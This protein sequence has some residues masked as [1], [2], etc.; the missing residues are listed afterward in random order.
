M[1]S[2][3]SGL[4]GSNSSDTGSLDRPFRVAHDT[5]SSL[6]V[7]IAR[8]IDMEVIILNYVLLNKVFFERV[9]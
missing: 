6:V 1:P 2:P 4:V 3:M 7:F 9:F 8:I 5:T